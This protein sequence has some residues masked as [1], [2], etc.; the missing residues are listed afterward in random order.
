MISWLIG[1]VYK[2]VG[3]RGLRVG[4]CPADSRSRTAAALG[5]TTCSIQGL[6]AFQD[7]HTGVPGQAFGTRL[8]YGKSAGQSGS[9][10]TPEARGKGTL[11]G[12]SL[13]TSL[14]KTPPDRAPSSQTGGRAET[15]PSP[16]WV[17]HG[18][19]SVASRCEQPRQF[20]VVERQTETLRSTHAGAI[21]RTYGVVMT[22]RTPSSRLDCSRAPIWHRA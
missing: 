1:S 15:W 7:G 17:R 22:Q 8:G 6:I 16:R 5:P 12:T 13:G 11:I 18:S 14:G 20:R 10:H 2:Q 21:L 9:F 3:A 4:R 19:S